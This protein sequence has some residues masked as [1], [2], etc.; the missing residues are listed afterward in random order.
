MQLP[1]L[2]LSVTKM[3]GGIYLARSVDGSNRNAV[4]RHRR[5]CAFQK[6]EECFVVIRTTGIV[7]TKTFLNLLDENDSKSVQ[8]STRI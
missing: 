2:Q 3:S 7:N 8:W 4:M 6:F 1:S 5:M